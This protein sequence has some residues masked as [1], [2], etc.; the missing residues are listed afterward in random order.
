MSSADVLLAA[1]ALVLHDLAARGLD[2]AH[3]VSLLEDAVAGRQCWLDQWP[4]GAEHIAGLVAQD[5]QDRLV[6]GRVRWPRCTA[7]DDL[8]EHELR[9][10][11]ELGPDPHW[12]CER[13]GISVAPLGRLT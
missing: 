2:D 5:V 11:P 9:I 4:D 7:C 10:E 12:V 13:A 8:T 1:R 3:I 6:D